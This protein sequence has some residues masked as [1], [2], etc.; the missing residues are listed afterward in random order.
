M[1]ISYFKP[2]L[3]KE[4]QTERDYAVHIRSKDDTSKAVAQTGQ[5]KNEAK[6]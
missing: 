5:T 2:T 6:E 3:E 1:P 4:K